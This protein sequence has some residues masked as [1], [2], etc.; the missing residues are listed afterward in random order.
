VV[1]WTAGSGSCGFRTSGGYFKLTN[2]GVLISPTNQWHI[3][4]N[5]IRRLY[6]GGGIGT[7]YS[8]NSVYS[9]TWRN[10]ADQTRMELYD[11]GGL[12]IAGGIGQYSD[13]RIKKEIEDIADDEALNKLLLI[14]PKTYKYIDET[15]GTETVYGFIAQQIKTILPEAVNLIVSIP[16]NIYKNCN[17]LKNK[18]YV[19]I[20]LNV[21]IGT[22]LQIKEGM[23]DGKRV[24]ILEIYED[25]IIIDKNIDEDD[26]IKSCFIY[27]YEI[28]DFHG[29]KK[30]HIFTLNVCATQELHRIITRQ[31]TIIDDLI[32]RIEVLES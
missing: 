25:Y 3:C 24:N 27:G 23:D 2:T 30:D 28:K 14:E 29:L 13:S 9:H 15:R 22:V 17:Y 12:W 5:G 32:R 6:Y 11:N 20:P 19:S 26:N 4:D 31:Q 18:I 8:G 1:L 16:P 21:E 10:G 7:Y